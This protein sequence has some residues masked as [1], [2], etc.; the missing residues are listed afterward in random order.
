MNDGLRHELAK[1]LVHQIVLTQITLP[2]RDILAHTLTQSLKTN[3]NG[4][5]WDSTYGVHLLDP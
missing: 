5:D 4:G 3:I 1:D 2:K